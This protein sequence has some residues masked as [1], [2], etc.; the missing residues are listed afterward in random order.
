LEFD[1]YL[2]IYILSSLKGKAQVI[3]PSVQNVV[4]ICNQIT[5]LTLYQISSRLVTLLKLSN[6]LV[7]TVC[8]K[9]NDIFFQIFR[10]PIP[11][12]AAASFTCADCLHSFVSELP[13]ADILQM[14]LRYL[15]I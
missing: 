10:H 6:V 15:A 5:L 7:I 11:K 2:A 9:V 3:H 4:G 8:L 13:W 14:A 12:M 1:Q